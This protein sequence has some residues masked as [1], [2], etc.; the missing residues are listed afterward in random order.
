MSNHQQ[1]FLYRQFFRLRV[2]ESFGEAFQLLFSRIMSYA[3]PGFQSVTPCGSWGDGGNDGWIPEDLHYFQVYGPKPTTKISETE[4]LNKAIKDYEKIPLKWGLV[5]SYSFVM[6]D[7]FVGI[8]GPI[9]AALKE[10]KSSKGLV[11]TGTIG[12]MELLA[13]FMSLPEDIRQDIVGGVPSEGPDFVDPRAVGELLSHLSEKASPSLSFL[14]ETAP[15]FE[16]KIKING[17]G[18]IVKSRIEANFYQSYTIDQFL[19]AREESLRQAIAKE[20]ND[21]YK[22]SKLSIPESVSDA[23]D[24]RYFWMIDKLIPPPIHEKHP[25]SLAAYRTAAEIVLAK[26]FESCDAYEH[27]DNAVTA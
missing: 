10:L 15:E 8:P 2:H 4:A 24:L 21:T 5:K 9:G 14:N 7:R 20:I 1:N 6:N 18:K 23:A 12:G 19:D 22:E 27:P 26:Y 11:H 25:H 3:H 17:I 13:K 16:K